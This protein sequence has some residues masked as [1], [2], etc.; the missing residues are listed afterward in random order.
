MRAVFVV[1]G[2]VLAQ[3]VGGWFQIRVRSRSSVR[4][5]CIQGLMREFIRGI[6][7]LV[8]TT[9]RPASVIRASKAVVNFESRAR[10]RNRALLEGPASVVTVCG[11]SWAV[12]SELVAVCVAASAAAV[13][14]SMV[15]G[16]AHDDRLLGVI[17]G[18]GTSS[19]RPG[20]HHATTS[21]LTGP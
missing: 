18:A 8:V 20:T 15:G 5:V 6:R 13:D 14:A 3:G 7:T 10:I 19:L 1:E 2:F 12:G 21:R 16:E 17:R 9:L 11:Q 4:Q